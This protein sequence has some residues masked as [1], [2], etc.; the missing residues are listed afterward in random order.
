MGIFSTMN[1]LIHELSCHN[2][3]NR[4]VALI[5]NGSWALASGKLMLEEFAKMKNI[6]II[7]PPVS[8]K[9]TVKS[10]NIA[11]IAVLADS[12]VQDMKCAVM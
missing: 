8:I 1:H 5:E 7:E 12:I 3:Q 11:E 4:T 6:K 10:H 9:S 2:F